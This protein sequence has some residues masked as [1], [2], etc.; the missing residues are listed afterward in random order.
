MSL[1][2]FAY[3]EKANPEHKVRAVQVTDDNQT[4]ILAWVNRW[5]K[6]EK[7]ETAAV[8]REPKDRLIIFTEQGARGAV[9]GD[10]VIRDKTKDYDWY[11]DRGETFERLYE[12]DE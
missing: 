1:K 10:Y 11:V 3:R 8:K 12:L 9:A 2:T 7:T 6:A 5:G 4:E